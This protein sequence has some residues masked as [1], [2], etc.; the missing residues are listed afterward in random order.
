MIGSPRSIDRLGRLLAGPGGPS[1]RGPFRAPENAPAYVS[2][3]G[4]AATATPARPASTGRRTRS[5][6]G[7]FGAALRSTA[8]AFLRRLGGGAEQR[9]NADYRSLVHHAPDVI[10]VLDEDFA[11]RY[12]SPSSETLLGYPDTNYLGT[13]F[14]QHLH[15]EEA[16]RALEAIAKVAKQTTRP[17]DPVLFTMRHADGSW[18]HMEAVCADLRREPDVRGIAC[19]VRDVTDRVELQN[20]LYHRAFHDSLTGLPNRALL[21]D[22]IQ[23]GLARASRHRDQLLAVLFVDLNDF[24]A[25]NDRWGHAVGDQILIAVGQRLRSCLR[26]SDTAARIGGDEFAVLLQDARGEDGAV[27]VARRILQALQSPVRLEDHTLSIEVSIGIATTQNP[28]CRQAETLLYASDKAMYEA[29]ATGEPGYAVFRDKGLKDGIIQLPPGA[30][31]QNLED[32][33][34]RSSG[35]E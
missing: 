2:L 24:K 5:F 31:R 27:R 23:Q 6:T 30:P 18:R 8:G 13:G 33:L 20:L 17:P 19:Y 16:E 21:M 29:K 32:H 35:A 12:T 10:F 25:I 15:P 22:R 11:V 34:S 28:F 14:G 4:V 7:R 9:Y 3:P 1:P 26:P